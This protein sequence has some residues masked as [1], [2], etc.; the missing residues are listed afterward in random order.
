MAAAANLF[1]NGLVSFRRIRFKFS[2]WF[3]IESFSF[4]VDA[5]VLEFA[6]QIKIRLTGVLSYE[7][8]FTRVRIAHGR[9]YRKIVKRTVVLA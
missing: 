4:H 1:T 2:F 5:F 8:A 3:V 9:G 6:R 7:E